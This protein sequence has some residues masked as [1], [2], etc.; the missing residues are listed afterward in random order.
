MEID[1]KEVLIGYAGSF[2]YIEGVSFLLKAFR[3]LVEKYEN[4][5]LI[6]IGGSN[7]P[8]SDDVLFLIDEL[9]L[10]GKVTRVPPQPHEFIPK[11]L[12]ACDLV[13]SPKIDC[14]ENRAANPAKVVEYLSM[15]LPTVCSAVGGIV[16]MIDDGVDGFLVNPGDVKD[17]EKTLEWVILNPERSKEIGESGRRKVIE[18][19][20]YEAIGRTIRE[21]LNEVINR[22]C[23][24]VKGKGQDGL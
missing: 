16:D 2:W 7:V 20:S 18:K 12:S 3:N 1:D 9:S 4:I 24:M 11:Y 19:Y 5:K 22:K 14:V 17:L 21:S 13:C 10:K 23:G 8:S 6:V 15:G